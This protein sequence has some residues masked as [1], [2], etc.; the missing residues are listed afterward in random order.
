MTASFDYLPTL[1]T[2]LQADSAL[3]TTLTGGIYLKRAIRGGILTRDLYPTAYDSGRTMKPLLIIV[4]RTVLPAPNGP[5]DRSN[6]Y[7]ATRQGIE[8]W[9]HQDA[10]AQ[11]TA[12]RTAANRL[13]ALLHLQPYAGA[14]QFQFNGEIEFNDPALNNAATLMTDYVLIGSRKAS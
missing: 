8:F 11:F 3:T 6:Q 5:R 4:G 1:L 10:A 13:Y 14:A 12:L 2:A 9:F 7:Q